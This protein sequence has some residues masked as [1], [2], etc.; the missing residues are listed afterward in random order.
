[1]AAALSD[2]GGRVTF[3]HA[4]PGEAWITRR[5]LRDQVGADAGRE[6][7]GAAAKHVTD[8]GLELQPHKR[9]SFAFSFSFVDDVQA[10]ANAAESR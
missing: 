9:S 8:S 4:R 6:F 10:G 7:L 3:P 2:S 5:G 1:M